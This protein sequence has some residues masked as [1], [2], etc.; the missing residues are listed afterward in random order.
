MKRKIITILREDNKLQYYKVIDG[1]LDAIS[2][3]F[4][5]LEISIV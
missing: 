5:D 4:L 1:Q 2:T 3:L